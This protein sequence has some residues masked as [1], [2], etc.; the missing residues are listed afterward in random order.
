MHVSQV[1]T[2]ARFRNILV[3]KGVTQ[4]IFNSSSRKSYCLTFTRIYFHP[5]T[6]H[7]LPR[8]QILLQVFYVVFTQSSAK[9]LILE[10]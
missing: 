9:S 3:T 1:L 4:W 8:V 10:Y 5:I 6:F 7:P 2:T